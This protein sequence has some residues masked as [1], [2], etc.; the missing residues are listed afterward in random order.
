MK[1]LNDNSGSPDQW[2]RVWHASTR[3]PDGVALVATLI[4]LSLVTFMTVAFLGVARRERRAVSATLSQGDARDAMHAALEHAQTDLIERLIT[5]DDPWSYSLIVSTNFINRTSLVTTLGNQPTDANY[6][7]AATNTLQHQL[8]NLANLQ[9]LPWVPVWHEDFTNASGDLAYGN[10]GIEQAYGRFYYD[11]NQNGFFEPTFSVGYAMP[12]GGHTFYAEALPG[13]SYNPTNSSVTGHFVGDPQWIGIL[14]DPTRPHSRENRFVGRYCYLIAPIGKSLDLNYIHNQ[15]K[16]NTN[17]Y[18]LGGSPSRDAYLRGMGVG[19]WDLNLGAFI[20]QLNTNN[21]ANTNWIY[22]PYENLPIPARPAPAPDVALAHAASVLRYRYNNNFSGVASVAN[23]YGGVGVSRLFGIGFDLY[24]EL[25]PVNLSG[26][27]DLNY[28][29]ILNR[30]WAGGTNTA[31]IVHFQHPNELLQRGGIYN[32]FAEYLNAVGGDTN[33]LLQGGYPLQSGFGVRNAEAFH[34]RYTFYRL[35]SQLGTDSEPENGRMNLN[36]DNISTNG[37]FVSPDNSEIQDGPFKS[38]SALRFFTNVAQSLL[39][40][41]VETNVYPRVVGAQTVYV[42]NYSLGNADPNNFLATNGNR[43][44]GVGLIS[45]NP[46]GAGGWLPGAFQLGIPQFD[47]TTNTITYTNNKLMISNIMVYPFNMFTPEVHRLFQVAANLY[48]TAGNAREWDP[49]ISYPPGSRVRRLSRYY[50]APGGASAGAD[51]ASGGVWVFDEPGAPT[52]FRPTFRFDSA[53]D[54]VYL[55]GFI[56]ESNTAWLSLPYLDIATTNDRFRFLRLPADPLFVNGTNM[57]IKGI[58]AIIGA[59]GPARDASGAIVASG[60]PA[61]NEV[62]Y[63]PFIGVTRKM[64]LVKTNAADIPRMTNSMYILSVSVD[65]GAEVWLPYQYTYPRN[66]ELRITNELS[67]VITNQYG[68]VLFSRVTNGVV[69]VVPANTWVPL[70]AAGSNSIPGNFRTPFRANVDLLRNMAYST[71]FPPLPGMTNGGFRPA[72]SALANTAGFTGTNSFQAAELG[73]VVSNWFSYSAVDTDLNLVVDHVN[74]T[75]LS[76]RVNFI[77]M[78]NGRTNR[79]ARDPLQGVFWRTNRTAFGTGSTN[80]T[81]SNTPAGETYQIMV[82]M[83]RSPIQGMPISSIWREFSLDSFNSRNALRTADF[84][85]FATQINGPSRR[86]RMQVPFSPTRKAMQNLTF[87][88]NDPLVHYSTKDLGGYIPETDF[89]FYPSGINPGTEQIYIRNHNYAWGDRIRFRTL[90]GGTLPQGLTNGVDYY[91][92]DV[93]NTDP[94]WL[95]FSL[96]YGGLPVDIQTFGSGVFVAM[97]Q[98]TL[99]NEIIALSS[100]NQPRDILLGTLGNTNDSYRPWGGHPRRASG[101]TISEARDYKYNLSIKDPAI[102]GTEYWNF[103]E[104]RFPS[105]GWMGRVHRGTPWQTIYMKSAIANTNVWDEWAGSFMTHPTNDWQL[106]DA[107]AAHLNDNASRGLLSV[108]QT[109]AAAWAAVLGGVVAIGNSPPYYTNFFPNKVSYTITPNTHAFRLIHEGIVE[110][111]RQQG[112]FR[113]MGHVLSV[114]ELSVGSP[115]LTAGGLLWQVGGNFPRGVFAYH[116]GQRYR[117]I[118]NHI[119]TKELEPPNATRWA[120]TWAATEELL[121]GY[122]DEMVEQV[123][124]QIMG[125]LKKEEYPR[126][127]IYAFGQKLAPAEQSVYLFPGDFMGMVTNYQV[128]GEM[129]SK[130]IIRIEG[131]PEPGQIPFPNNNSYVPTVFPRVVVEDHR[132][133]TTD[134]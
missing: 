40:A 118:A 94:F 7:Y 108:N 79:Y 32:E 115:F 99:G 33:D 101:T 15:A 100:T 72:N 97:S 87:E 65:M 14:Q 60:L 116:R 45:R 2:P 30:P 73:M 6:P 5:A 53:N 82:G 12:T 117:S 127:A 50:N 75:N 67:L 90:Q 132:L 58:P 27:Y 105:I 111:H 124:Q 44:S 121:Y 48:E 10:G 59:R 91:V 62:T 64:E 93:D 19:S 126:V 131:L 55:S 35:M 18:T 42:T 113:R 4:M 107:F 77:E 133:L 51:P 96:T 1:T 110:T 28:Q 134:Q 70:Q 8:R 122:T 23:M 41:S 68:P 57:H 47:G 49:G 69:D 112:G 78:L 98:V 102:Y 76:G 13:F 119:A 86:L 83:G 16:E 21:F 22:G 89:R 71:N 29:N 104:R 106:F 129:A 61:L 103:P 46:D 36:F 88:A 34:S 125:L 128:V 37:N 114:P 39:D 54:I 81:I 95:T 74:L 25:M 120:P 63:R 84:E 123:P 52:V 3:K 66:L 11:F 9:H 24:S 80:I 130:T 85:N 38:W 92:V 17:S 31:D 109:N 43:F 20:S 26:V 56:A